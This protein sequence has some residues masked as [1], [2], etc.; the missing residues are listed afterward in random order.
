MHSEAEERLR[1]LPW[2][3][4]RGLAPALDAPLAG[5]LA[6][7]PADAA[8]AR[9]LRARPGLGPEG[10]A[11]V[12][13]AVLGVA[14]WRRRLRVALGSAG[15][16]PRLL[17]AALLRE[18]AGRA[19]AADLCGLAEGDLP[20]PTAPPD[21][22]ADRFS[23]P[24]WLADEIGAAVGREADAL[25][26]ALDLPG[27][28]C[29][30]VNTLRA[31][32]AELAARLS[33]EGVATRPGTLAPECLVVTS[34]RPNVY[35]LPSHRE[36]LFEVQDE[37]SQLAGRSLGARAGDVV[38]DLCAGAGGK[39]LLLAAAVGSGGCV[40]TADP[41]AEKLSRL[42][43]RVMRAG[44]RE[45]V[46]VHGAEPPLALLADR[47][48]VDAP[49]SE[50]GVLRRGPDARWRLDPASFAALPELQL[51]IL[52]RAARHVRPG[53]TLVYATCTPLREENE[54]VVARFVAGSRGEAT[55][56]PV[57]ADWPGPPE[58]RTPDGFIRLSPHRDGTDGFFAAVLRRHL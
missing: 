22:L 24:D 36:G 39:A 40:H 45:I 56:A 35:G 26:D 1:T 18:L 15:A 57:P 8:L 58:A 6:G 54:E 47:V 16:R 13:E 9:F 55:V 14:L 10:R 41:D 5:V 48:L 30:R 50:L 23:F 25:G 46:Q 38:L 11:A 2:E 20:P 3:A 29:L 31:S 49:C 44:A 42:R 7:D 32:T 34:P 19:D 51:G 21:A 52:A 17:L 33:A 12:A 28:V 53:G 27:P 43:H 37:G 4:L